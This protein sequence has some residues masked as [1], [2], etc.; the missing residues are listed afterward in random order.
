MKARTIGVL[1][2][3]AAAC[4]V[5]ASP[6]APDPDPRQQAIFGAAQSRM[7]EQLD[8]WFEAGDYP[9]CIQLLRTQVSLDPND[10]EIATNLGWLLESV[11][12]Y[13]EALSVYVQYRRNNPMDPDGSFPEAHFYFKRKAYAKVPA[14]L[15]P[16]LKLGPHGNSFRILAHSYEK[17]GMIGDSLRV[18]DKFL[19]VAPNDPQAKANRQRV[20]GKMRADATRQSTK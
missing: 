8:V 20:M 18:W 11:D 5:W 19:D 3:A 16:S 10:Y 6:N 13:D 12:A 7:N 14:L 4:A 2:V 9:R 15:E 17:M 1:A